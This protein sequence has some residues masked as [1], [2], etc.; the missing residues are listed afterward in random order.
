M[1]QIII[2]S[3][4]NSSSSSI[5]VTSSLV[6]QRRIADAH[7]TTVGFDFFALTRS[8][9]GIRCL[10]T[11]TTEY[12]PCNDCIYH[13]V[14]FVMNSRHHFNNVTIDHSTLSLIVL[15]VWRPHTGCI[16]T[17]GCSAAT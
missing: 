4:S 8:Y 11:A 15:V 3:S 17:S 2:S 1:R 5:K 10:T 14:L 12:G 16:H 13:N 9:L 6:A 7:L